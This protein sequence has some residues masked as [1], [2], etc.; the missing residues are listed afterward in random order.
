MQITV[1]KVINKK[2]SNNI[3]INIIL[4]SLSF[5]LKIML[6]IKKV[7][8]ANINI[9]QKENSVKINLLST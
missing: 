7:K 8:I 4:H 2:A 3:S 5:N 6:E 9:K 1:K